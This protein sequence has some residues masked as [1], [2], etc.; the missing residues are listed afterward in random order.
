MHTI[1][2]MVVIYTTLEIVGYLLLLKTESLDIA[3]LE[4]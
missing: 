2:E 4:L 3:T 1:G